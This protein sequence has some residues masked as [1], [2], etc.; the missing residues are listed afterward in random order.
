MG[1]TRRSFTI[2]N[3]IAAGVTR[4]SPMTDHAHQASVPQ[5]GQ[6]QESIPLK[7]ASTNSKRPHV[8]KAFS[9]SSTRASLFFLRVWTNWSKSRSSAELSVVSWLTSSTC[10]LGS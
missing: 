4:R 1:E 8:L 9:M 7:E 10:I 6:E 5:D 3:M 2:R